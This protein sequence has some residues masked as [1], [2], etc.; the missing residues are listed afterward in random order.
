M[1][2]N[3]RSVKTEQGVNM[4]HADIIKAAINAW[5]K[6]GF[7]ST[8]LN[9]VAKEL[10][11]T[12]Q[13]IYRYYPGKD[14]LIE[15]IRD[16]VDRL[17]RAHYEALR[18]AMETAE[19]FKE[20]MEL[21]VYAKADSL[22]THPAE[23]LFFFVPPNVKIY[24]EQFPEFYSG[25]EKREKELFLSLFDKTGAPVLDERQLDTAYVLVQ[26]TSALGLLKPLMEK[27]KEGSSVSKEE[28][29]VIKQIVVETLCIG[30][31]REDAVLEPVDAE[32]VANIAK[33]EKEELPELHKIFEVVEKLINTKGMRGTSLGEVARELGMSKSSLYSHFKDKESMIKTVM[34]NQ[35]KGFMDPLVTRLAMCRNTQEKVLCYILY[36]AAYVELHSRILGIMAWLRLNLPMPHQEEKKEQ[37]F[38]GQYQG[39]YGI[40]AGLPLKEEVKQHK[41]MLYLHALIFSSLERKPGKFF[42]PED[43]KDIYAFFLRGLF[44]MANKDKFF[45]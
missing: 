41:P 26:T 19:S 34:V 25:M 15:A 17:H 32:Y 28:L 14:A 43:A 1:F 40:F 27:Y 22:Y 7:S 18:A 38:F 45:I 31:C 39:L 11:V 30:I 16:E 8:S 4:E 21:F 24:T 42:S 33:V 12:K 2:V 13:A 20:A 3:D 10:G 44:G 29:S 5:A 35:I 37:D 9:D 23:Y 36:S 6:S